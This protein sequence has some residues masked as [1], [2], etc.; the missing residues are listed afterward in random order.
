[1]KRKSKKNFDLRVEKKGSKSGKKTPKDKVQRRQKHPTLMVLQ[2]KKRS[3]KKGDKVLF[4]MVGTPKKAVKKNQKKN[5]E[6]VK[7]IFH[8]K[9]EK[10]GP[11]PIVGE[12]A[13][14]GWGK[15]RKK[16]SKN[17]K[18]TPNVVP[19]TTVGW[20]GGFREGRGAGVP[21]HPGGCQ[22]FDKRSVQK[23]EG[24][25]NNGFDVLAVEKGGKSGPFEAKQK[26]LTR[27]A[28]NRTD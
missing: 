22:K 3:M 12:K 19:K 11:R 28:L 26:N 1:V 27:S 14:R 24:S 6:S 5:K 15:K 21:Q 10:L 13:G 4:G 18:K 8:K 25:K 16:T 17:L 2:L 20:G 23:K 7:R 9:P